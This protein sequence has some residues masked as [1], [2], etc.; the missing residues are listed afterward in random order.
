ML[1][2]V[3]NNDGKRRQWDPVE[4]DKFKDALR[5]LGP[6]SNVEIA[7]VIG[8]RTCKQVG[9]FKRAFLLKN[10]TWLKDN[11][12]TH[13]ANPALP[14]QQSSSQLTPLPIAK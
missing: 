6:S 7:K 10:P 8:T 12:A 5:R 4:I 2:A 3:N 14:P 11:N 9:V 1:G 13:D